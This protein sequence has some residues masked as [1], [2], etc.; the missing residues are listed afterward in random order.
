[1]LKCER[2]CLVKTSVTWLWSDRLASKNK[3]GDACWLAQ[4]L[5]FKHTMFKS[6]QAEGEYGYYYKVF[7][8]IQVKLSIVVDIY[9]PHSQPMQTTEK[10]NNLEYTGNS[11]QPSQDPMNHFRVRF[12]S[13]REGTLVANTSSSCL[14]SP[15]YH[16]MLKDNHL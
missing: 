2:A 6:S 16:R 12:R 1:M 3:P 14:P 15:T 5:T 10:R 11:C 13:P 4:G 9:T 8:E 7:R